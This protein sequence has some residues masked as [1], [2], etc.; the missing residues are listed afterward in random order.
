VPPESHYFTSEPL[1]PAATRQI[2]V[3]L[4]GRTAALATAPGVFSPG[5]IDLGT[6]VLLRTLARRSERHDLP[7]SGLFVDLGSGWGPLALT[8][9]S[10]APAARVAAVEVNQAARQLTAMNARQMGLTNVTVIDPAESEAVADIDVL[11]SNPPIRIGKDA[12]HQLLAGWLGRLRPD[13][14]ADLVVQRNLG[15]D[16]LHTWLTDAGFPTERLASAK[17]FR[18]LR[19]HAMA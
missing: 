15:A 4:A 9:A 2:E 5:R 13:G 16:S 17:G 10:L 1:D 7:P 14:H 8:M 3:T 12:L 18:V 11:W 19:A 6:A